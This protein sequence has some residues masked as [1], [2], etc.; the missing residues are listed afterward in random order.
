LKVRAIADDREYLTGQRV[1]KEDMRR[2]ALEKDA[3]HG[4]WN[5]SIKPRQKSPA[6]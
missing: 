4:E 3:F 2:L 1:T 5:D 6:D